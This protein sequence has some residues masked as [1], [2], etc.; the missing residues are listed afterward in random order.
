[1]L[2]LKLKE[3]TLEVLEDNNI[4][5]EIADLLEVIYSIL[6]YKNIEIEKI[7]KI[8]ELKK[9]KNGGFDKKIILEEILK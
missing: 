2:K 9:I 7:E 3:E 1:M 6:K 4:E 8:R 5:E